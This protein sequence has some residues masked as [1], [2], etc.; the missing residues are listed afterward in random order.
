MTA[1]GKTRPVDNGMSG[2]DV[3]ATEREWQPPPT[4]RCRLFGHKCEPFKAKDG[5]VIVTRHCKRCGWVPVGE[6][7][8]RGCWLVRQSSCDLCAVWIGPH[9]HLLREDGTVGVVVVPL[10]EATDG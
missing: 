10:R 1:N 7:T 6:A 2:E 8:E 9:A 5:R 4:L 3:T